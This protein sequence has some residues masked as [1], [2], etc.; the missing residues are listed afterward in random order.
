MSDP[1]S[2]DSLIKSLGAQAAPVR[3][4]LSPGRRAAGWAVVV[5]AIAAY[6]LWRYGL[7][8]MMERW[9][10][11]P[12]VACSALAA[13]A[14]CIAAG[15]AA[16]A[17]AVPGSSRAWM[18]VPLPSLLVWLGSSGW[19][20]MR[21]WLTPDSA[22]LSVPSADCL[23]FIVALS[24]PLSILL[25]VLLRR[26]FPLHPVRAAA[27]IGLASASASAGLL[28]IFH[29]IDASASD[30][31]MHVVAVLLVIGV[32]AAMGGRLLQPR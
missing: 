20:C 12:D 8:G 16:F 26:A 29:P 11:A 28:G 32:N 2:I 14:T 27:M 19:G 31:A 25:I 7:G 24:V 6:L 22:P 4:L 15:W 5:A 21:Y 3:R 18:L 1:A 17:L 13:F 23:V 30:L 9:E 10:R